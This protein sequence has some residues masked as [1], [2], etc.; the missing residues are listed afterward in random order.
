MQRPADQ[1]SIRALAKQ[2]AVPVKL[3]REAWEAGERNYTKAYEH[4]RIVV[5]N[6]PHKL[7]VTDPQHP[8]LAEADAHQRLLSRG[9]AY[10]HTSFDPHQYAT[11]TYSKGPQIGIPHVETFRGNA[12]AFE[13]HTN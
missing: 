3:A 6:G 5:L 2:F 1:A 10:Q 4:L 8:A 12:S 9:Y 13:V 7:K 11:H